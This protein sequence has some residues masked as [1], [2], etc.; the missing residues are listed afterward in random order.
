MPRDNANWLEDLRSS[1]SRQA[2]ALD[3]LRA[4]IV[5]S[6]PLA[7]S[8]WLPLDDPRLPALADEVAQDTLMRV[9]ARLDIFQGRS[10]SATWVH[11]IAVQCRPLALGA[12]QPLLDFAARHIG[13]GPEAEL[14]RSGSAKG[15]LPV[16]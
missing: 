14:L 10:K 11:A 13:P 12:R 16:V 3:D 15:A 6:L 1:D 7:L 8:R 5:R 2:G 9:L 4:M